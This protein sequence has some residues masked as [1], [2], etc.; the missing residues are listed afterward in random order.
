[1]RAACGEA[2]RRP[3]QP[4]AGDLRPPAAG[5]QPRLGRR[6]AAGRQ[7]EGGSGLLPLTA[8]PPGSFLVIPHLS[9]FKAI[10]VLGAPPD[11]AGDW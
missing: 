3:S 8:L 7:Q 11:R 6:A 1:M 2:L 4:A 10:P 5:G 9:I